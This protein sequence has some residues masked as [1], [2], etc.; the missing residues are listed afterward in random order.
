[1]PNTEGRG[2]T[3]DGY[4]SLGTGYRKFVASNTADPHFETLPKSKI[5]F[6]F[7]F[8]ITFGYV[9]PFKKRR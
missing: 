1:M 3:V 6:D 8:G 2:F 7:N 4:V 5:P 9:Y